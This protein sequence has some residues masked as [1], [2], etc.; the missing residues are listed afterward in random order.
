MLHDGIL[1]RN[2][3]SVPR[4]T[5]LQGYSILCEGTHLTASKLHYHN[6]RSSCRQVGVLEDVHVKPPGHSGCLCEMVRESEG[7]DIEC[8]D[9]R[10]RLQ[11]E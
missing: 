11:S 2:A 10:D 1:P 6:G 9:D 4:L 3:H 5:L 8:G 7:G